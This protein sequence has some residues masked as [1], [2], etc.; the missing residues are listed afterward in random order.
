MWTLNIVVIVGTHLHLVGDCSYLS[1]WGASCFQFFQFL[2]ETDRFHKLIMLRTPLWGFFLLLFRIISRLHY[3]LFIK[4]RH[5]LRSNWILLG[6]LFLFLILFIEHNLIVCRTSD[7]LIVS[8]AS[9]NLFVFRVNMCAP[10]VAR[11]TIW[12]PYTL[13][14]SPSLLLLMILWVCSSQL[15]SESWL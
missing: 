12:M 15:S 3:L 6:F 9:D 1:G 7:Y 10:D 2:W 11:N 14:L 5:H 13:K 4:L 8:S